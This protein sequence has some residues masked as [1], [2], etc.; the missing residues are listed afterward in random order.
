V[1]GNVDCFS[2]VAMGQA[3]L[4]VWKGVSQI[5]KHHMF[6]AWTSLFMVGFTDFYIWMVATGRI[7]DMR[8]F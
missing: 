4:K 2:C 3:R 1:G 5:N 6:W 8:I 7:V